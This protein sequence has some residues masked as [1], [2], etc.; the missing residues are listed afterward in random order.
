M[1]RRWPFFI[2]GGVVL[3][4]LGVVAGSLADPTVLGPDPGSAVVEGPRV[5]DRVRDLFP[6]TRGW[7][8][9]VE[10]ARYDVGPRG[11]LVPDYESLTHP[12]VRWA[13]NAGHT[14]TSQ[15]ARRYLDATRIGSG[16]DPDVWIDLV[17]ER[18]RDVPARIEDGLIVY[19]G[20][21][22]KT[23]VLYKSTPTHVDEYLLLTGPE[24]P[25]RWSYS[26]R[27]GPRIARLRQGGSSV[28]ALDA[29]GVPWLRARPPFAV[30]RNGTKA[31]GT[32]RVEGDRLVVSIDPS[33]LS[34]PIL[35][36]PDWQSTGDMSHGRFYHGANVLTDS[37]VLVTGGC[38]SSVCSGDLSIPA[39]RTVPAA[40]EV[41]DLSSRRW[42]TIA[43]AAQGTFFHVAESLPDGSVLIAGGCG[44]PD[45]SG[46]TDMAEIF[47]L[48]TSAFRTIDPLPE[49]VAGMASARLSDGK[50]LVAGGCTIRDCT[51]SSWTFDPATETFTTVAALNVARGRATTT[52]LSDGRVLVTG[53]CTTINCDAVMDSAEIYDPARDS[54][55]AAGSMTVPRGG[56]YAALLS[57]G[58]V[59][60]GGGCAEQRCTTVYRSAEFFDPA[61]G[62]FT[63]A[64]MMLQ[65]RT[66]ALALPLPSGEIMIS[67][68]CG[69][70]SACDL[71]NEA[72]SPASGTFRM[73]E[74]AITTRAFHTLTMHDAAQ[75]II[76][77]GGCQ[78]TTCSWWNETYDLSTLSHDDA[79][80]R[81][82]DAGVVGPPSDEGGCPCSVPAGRGSTATWLGWMALLGVLAIRRRRRRRL[83]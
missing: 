41:L 30:D 57:D 63:D 9:I 2:A 11:R 20:A 14:V 17:P 6:Q 81:R 62:E 37:R 38:S 48:A 3:V 51:T 43:N 82:R 1:K 45:C 10:T 36:D 66:G 53:G 31:Y 56:H 21:Y 8:R 29:E 72:F 19:A 44:N 80:V 70:G 34:H 4:G 15:L 49:A 64:G 52:V 76:A 32:I 27:T 47:E 50:I 78:P 23:D 69:S 73:I 68:G 75:L 79:G 40:A 39:C 5:V 7:F 28:E 33:G 24:A 55:D 67:Q 13:D 71:T 61:T 22:P 59:L 12:R 58:R 25:T 60:V 74:P 46:V 77:I 65:A 54:W 83:L 35:V 26:V 18:G 16:E 42:S